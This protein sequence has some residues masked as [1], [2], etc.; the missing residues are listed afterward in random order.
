MDDKL[1]FTYNADSG[2]FS[3]V[4]DYFHKIIK[5]QT[6]Q[7]KLCSLTYGNLG[8]KHEWKEFTEGLDIPVE[9]L[10]RDE[11]ISKYPDKKHE[12]PCA[13]IQR[14]SELISIIAKDEMNQ[15]ETLDELIT[16]VKERLKEM[17]GD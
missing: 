15:M 4:E 3:T 10:H 14:D 8:M 13:H 16:A 17:Y 11:F 2:I 12:F 9:F 5:P 1:V 7:C 6:Y